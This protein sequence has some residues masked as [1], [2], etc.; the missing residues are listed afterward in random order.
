MFFG[1]AKTKTRLV[2]IVLDGDE[3]RL[4]RVFSLQGKNAFTSTFL[5]LKSFSVNRKFPNAG[6]HCHRRPPL[7]FLLGMAGQTGCGFGL[8]L[9]WFPGT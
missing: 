9:K 3:V 8:S 4:K 1:D 2:K 6:Q 5:Y 7:H